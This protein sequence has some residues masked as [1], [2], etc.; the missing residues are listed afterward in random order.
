[1]NQQAEPQENDIE[2]V[3]GI[4]ARIS[5]KVLGVEFKI[6]VERDQK[7]PKDGRVFL[8]YFYVAPCT[9]TGEIKEWSCRKWYLSEYMTDDEI[10][11]TAFGALK[12]AMEHEV[13]ES[14]QIDGKN[15]FNPHVH[16]TTLLSVTDKEVTRPD[17]RKH[18]THSFE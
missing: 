2:K 9:R 7:H 17:G 13:M 4:V 11:K 6:R 12:A 5:A 1:M 10:V 8:Q 15:P 14:F 16:F 18:L 3:K